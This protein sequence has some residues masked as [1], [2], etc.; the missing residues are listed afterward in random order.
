MSQASSSLFLLL[1][2]DGSDL[3]FEVSIFLL[4]AFL[5]VVVTEG[6]VL[7]GLLRPR[8]L[9]VVVLEVVI[10]EGLR[11]L[12]VLEESSGEV[13]FDFFLLWKDLT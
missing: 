6:C 4:L 8:L 2:S 11:L 10:R 5:S 7:E 1:L 9:G 12:R 13:V 3:N